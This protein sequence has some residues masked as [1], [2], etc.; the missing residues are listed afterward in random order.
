M[1]QMGDPYK[2]QVELVNGNENYDEFTLLLTERIG[3]EKKD[4]TRIRLFDMDGTSI[5][6]AATVGPKQIQ[7]IVKESKGIV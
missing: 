6:P 7:Y 4:A 5:D 2:F 3:L 1:S